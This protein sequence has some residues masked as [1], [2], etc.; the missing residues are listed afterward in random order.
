MEREHRPG[1][2]WACWAEDPLSGA[3]QL[4]LDPLQPQLSV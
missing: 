3:P 1:E 4:R 2:A